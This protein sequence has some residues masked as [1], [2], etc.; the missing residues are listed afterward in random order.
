M[1]NKMKTCLILLVILQCKWVLI[2]YS[3][4]NNSGDAV[5][6]KGYVYIAGRAGTWIATLQNSLAVPQ[7][8]KHIG[9]I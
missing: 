3:C 2:C 6:M 7:A 4:Y 8:E 1:A 5:V 9:T